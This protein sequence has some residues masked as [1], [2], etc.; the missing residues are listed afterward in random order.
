MV[1]RPFFLGFAHDPISA[2]A[3]CRAKLK[4]PD[5]NISAGILIGK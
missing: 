2:G 4:M 3:G 1:G 5:G